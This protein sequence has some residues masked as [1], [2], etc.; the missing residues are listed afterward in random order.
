MFFL[1]FI[2]GLVRST[3]S[4]MGCPDWPKCFG[5][6]IPPSDISELPLDYKTKFAVAGKEIADFDAFKTWTEYYNRLIGVVIGLFVFLTVIFALPY[7]KSTNKKIFWLSFLA[8][9]LVG[10]QGWIGSI[11]VSTDLATYMITIHML[12]ALIIVALLIYTVSASQD[13]VIYQINPFPGLKTLIWVL[14]IIAIVQTVSGTQVREAI[15]EI[16][17]RIDNRWVWTDNAGNIFLMHRSWSWFS[18]LISIYM[19]LQF[20]KIFLRESIL[21][22]ASLALVLL[23]CTQALSGAVLANLGFPSQFQSIHLTLG[24]LTVGLIIFISILVFTKIELKLEN[25]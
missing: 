14:L 3:G 24:S 16:A 6:W 22:K 9:I 20:K 4:G 21:Y 5:Q 2:G 18:L 10:F 12:I 7:L 23:M 19:M 8:F 25:K 17:K 1:I 11:V 15:D 13:F